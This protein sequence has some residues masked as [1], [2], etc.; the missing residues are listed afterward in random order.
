M[1][2]ERVRFVRDFDKYVW[3]APIPLYDST[4][5]L[6]QDLVHLAAESERVA[7]GVELPDQSFQ[8]LRRRIRA[9]LDTSGVT[10]RTDLLVTDLLSTTISD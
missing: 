1:I 9:S 6:H 4:N 7:Q 8:A 5:R 2:D 10:A 3:Q